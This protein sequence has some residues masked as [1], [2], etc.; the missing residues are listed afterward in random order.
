MDRIP[1]PELMDDPAQALAY[2]RADFAE[3]HQRF[4]DLARER[5]EALGGLPEP[6]RLADLGCGPGDITLRL[7]RAF[8]QARID[9]YDGAAPMLHL[10]RAELVAAGDPRLWQ[11]IH[12]HLC[13]LPSPDLPQRSFHAIL[14]NSLLHH[15]DDPHT[16]WR[17]LRQIGRPGALVAIMDL[18]RP[19]DTATARRLVETHSGDEP[20]ILKR[21]FYHSLLAA[22]TE[23][24]VRTQLRQ[25][26]LDQLHCERI[27]DRHLF[28]WGRLPH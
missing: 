2:A 20:D 28:V 13:H 7:A 1:E 25:A 19:Q 15:L 12:F 4:V 6:A 17:T 21:D 27:S 23:A 5:F 24:E 3:P 18:I 10:A 22:Y 8:P 16:L 11:R 9:A 14:S 26:G